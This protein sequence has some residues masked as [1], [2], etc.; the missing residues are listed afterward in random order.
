M[1]PKLDQISYTKGLRRIWPPSLRTERSGGK[2]DLRMSRFSCCRHSESRWPAFLQSPEREQ[3]VV[4]GNFPTQY[5]RGLEPRHNYWRSLAMRVNAPPLRIEVPTRRRWKLVSTI[6]LMKLGTEAS[7]TPEHPSAKVF[8][9][10][11]LLSVSNP[12]SH[13][14]LY[15]WNHQRLI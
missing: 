6:G 10:F 8:R 4:N 2:K 7:F 11:L 15:Q 13:L 5:H 14:P 9:N 12:W 1:G 3:Q